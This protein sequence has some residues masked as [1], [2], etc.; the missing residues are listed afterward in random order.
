MRIL[1]TT[2][3]YPPEIGGPATFVESFSSYLA[4]E[5]HEVTVLTF[6][7]APPVAPEGV[8]LVA[9]ARSAL[10]LRYL[11]FFREVLRLSRSSDLVYVCEHPRAFSVLAAKLRGRK[12]AVRMIVD[13]SWEIAYRFGW[14]T[15]DPTAYRRN[16]RGLRKRVLRASQ[17]W[18]L[19]RADLVVAVADHLARLAIDQGVPAE[20]IFVSYNLPPSR[21]DSTIHQRNISDCTRLLV[22]S[23]L[24]GWKGI[25]AVLE[26]LERLGPD[27]NLTIL[28]D[29][30]DRELIEARIDSLDL[31]DRVDLRGAVDHGA[32]R[33]E[34]LSN[35][36]L[37][38]NSDYEGLSHVLLEAMDSGLPI[39][40]TD[41]P[42]NRELLQDQRDAALVKPQNDEQL[43]TAIR[44]LA[45]DPE[46]RQRLAE[47]ARQ[48][49]ET[50]R[51]RH[52]FERLARRLAGI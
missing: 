3:V 17:S 15:D 39:V 28:G 14:T 25:P 13:T 47:G 21:Q 35:D 2:P 41:I 33:K 10:A 30:P 34:M 22:V 12:V 20:R 7:D 32:V 19:E 29:G 24:V 38:L 51:V 8:R 5:G 9:V 46:E 49:L 27:F 52:S 11:R 16:R 48:R 43:A 4:G 40:A 45:Q 1:I 50:I 23:R 31:R 36:L 18:S 44:R 26:V 6:A 42:G 37:I